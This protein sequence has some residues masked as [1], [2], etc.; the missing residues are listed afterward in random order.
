M[1]NIYSSILWVLY[2][3]NIILFLIWYYRKPHSYNKKRKKE[4]IHM[5][6]RQNKSLVA[7]MV[8]TAITTIVIEAC[9]RIANCSVWALNTDNTSGV[10]LAVWMPQ[11]YILFLGT[12]LTISVTLQ[13]VATKVPQNFCYHTYTSFFLCTWLLLVFFIPYFQPSYWSWHTQRRWLPSWPL[14]LPTYLPQLSSP[15]FWSISI[16]PHQT[17]LRKYNKIKIFSRTS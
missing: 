15:Q 2:A 10:F 13:S 4:Q 8:T 17:A 3:T 11:G 5:R 1:A 16:V 14:Y 9:A 7:G 6:I 12:G